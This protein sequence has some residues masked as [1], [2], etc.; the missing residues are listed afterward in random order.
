[1]LCDERDEIDFLAGSE[2]GRGNAVTGPVLPKVL[3]RRSERGAKPFSK[4]L[5]NHHRIWDAYYNGGFV[6]SGKLLV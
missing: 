5:F 4:P 2:D 6:A 3:G 1:M